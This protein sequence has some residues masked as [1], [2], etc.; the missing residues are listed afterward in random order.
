MA[1]P[2]VNAG[3]LHGQA[4]QPSTLVDLLRS[5]ASQHPEKCAYQFL[6]DGP[7]S[8]SALSYAQLYE[9]SKAT[10]AKLQQLIPH[11]ER[12]L[13]IYGPGLEALPALFGCM[14]SGVTAIPVPA[15]NSARLNRFLP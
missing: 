7:P 9:Q 2:L 12:A 13:V 4:F 5:K 3:D 14:L 1:Q 11:G 8:A 10:A 15:P 6:P